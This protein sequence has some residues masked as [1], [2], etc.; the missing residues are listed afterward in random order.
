MAGQAFEEAGVLHDAAG[1]DFAVG[2]AWNSGLSLRA[3]SRVMPGVS[4]SFWR[5]DHN[6]RVLFLARVRGR[7]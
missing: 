7:V 4:G 3:F 6:R 5:D 1:V 2:R